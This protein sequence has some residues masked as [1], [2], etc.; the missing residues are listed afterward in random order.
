[1]PWLV[2]INVCLDAIVLWLVAIDV[3][4]SEIFDILF[5]ITAVDTAVPIVNVKLFAGEVPPKLVP[6]IVIVSLTAYPDPA[7]A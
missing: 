5:K 7:L 3:C 6:R 2:A 4:L 1:M